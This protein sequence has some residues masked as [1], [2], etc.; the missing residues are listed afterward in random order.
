MYRVHPKIDLQTV[1]GRMNFFNPCLQNIPRDFEITTEN[2]IN[3][4]CLQIEDENTASFFDKI[5]EVVNKSSTSISLRNIF[6]A[7]QEHVLL[8]AVNIYILDCFLSCF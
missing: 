5:N 2:I 8:A 1:T 4:N 7:A 6:V 3:D